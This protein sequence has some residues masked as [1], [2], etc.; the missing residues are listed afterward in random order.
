M[1][2]RDEQGS[3]AISSGG[4]RRSPHVS[5]PLVDCSVSTASPPAILT[6]HA[7][8]HRDGEDELYY[9]MLLEE[10]PAHKLQV[11]AVLGAIVL[12]ASTAICCLCGKDPAGELRSTQ[13]LASC[14]CSR[15]TSRAYAASSLG[16]TAAR[17]VARHHHSSKLSG[18]L[19]GNCWQQTKSSS[20]ISCVCHFEHQAP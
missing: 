9:N 15:C 11:N 7:V 2:A 13:R 17:T 8:V 1:H 3:A 18:E 5:L 4:W 20:S 16:S 14:T 19:V 6:T 10:E 12:T